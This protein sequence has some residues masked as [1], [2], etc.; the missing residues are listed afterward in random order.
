VIE[1]GY[2]R[3]LGTSNKAEVRRETKLL[4]PIPDTTLR[5]YRSPITIPSE[6]E[7]VIERMT[8]HCRIVWRKDTR[9]SVTFE[10]LAPPIIR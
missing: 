3:R 2:L 9:M 7:L 10:G 8:R 5:A 6:L 4:C 1:R